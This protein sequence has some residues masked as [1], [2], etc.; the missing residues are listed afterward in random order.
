M[1]EPLTAADVERD[2]HSNVKFG[3]QEAKALRYIL[4]VLNGNECPLTQ[5]ALEWFFA[6]DMYCVQ[7]F[8]SRAED[9]W[10]SEEGETAT[11][12][13]VILG[14]DEAIRRRIHELTS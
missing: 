14:L 7:T 13:E 5:D 9:S 2:F 3:D 12:V 11:G 10:I 4:S 8:S 1:V 6:M